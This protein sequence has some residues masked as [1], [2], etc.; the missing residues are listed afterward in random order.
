MSEYQPTSGD[1]FKAEMEWAMC[2]NPWTI[3]FLVRV[4]DG[5]R[6]L[7]LKQCGNGA[8]IYIG[9]AG[10]CRALAAELLKTADQWESVVEGKQ[11][12]Q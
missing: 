10:N 8:E 6:S 12:P 9:S 7:A 2:E 4:Q 5:E 11:A 3:G 1:Q